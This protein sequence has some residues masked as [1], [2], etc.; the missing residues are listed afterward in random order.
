MSQKIQN[1]QK[2]VPK[3]PQMS[4]QDFITDQLS[5]E[6]Y[7]C[8]SYSLAATEASHAQLFQDINQIANETH[9]CQRDLFNVMFK[10]GLYSYDAAEQQSIQQDYQKFTGYK[11]QFPYPQGQGGQNYS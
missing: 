5:T 2:P 9:N 6:K 10:K 3:T 8:N 1:P 7:L 4:E 11:N